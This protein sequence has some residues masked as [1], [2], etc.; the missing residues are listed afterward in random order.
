MKAGLAQSAAAMTIVAE[1]LTRGVA[2]YL[3][4][5][6]TAA[7]RSQAAEPAAFAVGGQR[8]QAPAFCPDGTRHA[9]H[10]RRVAAS[11]GSRNLVFLFMIA[12]GGR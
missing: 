7:L 9:A 8:N 1:R 2:G 10:H 6:S 4:A 11:A 3:R 5:L 12:G